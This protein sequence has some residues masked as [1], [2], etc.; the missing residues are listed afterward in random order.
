M[1]I[2]K[3][4]LMVASAPWTLVLIL[5]VWSLLFIRTGIYEEHIYNV[6]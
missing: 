3:Q 6:F 4:M 1:N 5:P 2:N